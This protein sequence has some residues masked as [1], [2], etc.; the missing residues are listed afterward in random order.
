MC[1]GVLPTLNMLRRR[2][3]LRVTVGGIPGVAGCQA[4]DP[5]ADTNEST[6]ATDEGTATSDRYSDELSASWTR[7]PDMPKRRT[8]T[9]A[10][11]LDSQV[12]VIGGIVDGGDRHTAV[13][14]PDEERWRT[15]PPP[16]KPI[17]HTSAVAHGERI[18]VFGGYSGSFLGTDPL[19]VHWIYDPEQDAW[20]EGPP[21]PTARGALVAVVVDGLIYTI[22]GASKEGT[23]S[24]VEVYDPNDESWT[25]TASMPTAREHLSAGSIGG[26]AYAAGGRQGLT[27][28]VSATARYDPRTETWDSRSPMPTARA[29]IAGAALVGYLFVFGG[30]E[31]GER[32]FEEVEAYHPPTDTWTTVEPLPTPRWG[33]GAATLDGRIY[34]VGGGAVPSAKET[35]ALEIMTLD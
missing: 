10:V 14:V 18:H 3:F 5:T 21:L 7:G 12:Y 9:T 16:P 4:L 17:N 32:V 13:Y 19:D 24:A 26:R 1:P 33:L 2:T 29:G 15:A 27:P 11:A 8:Q 35:K 34:T 20:T 31:V 28:M 6:P 23:S 22:G 30:E 25:A